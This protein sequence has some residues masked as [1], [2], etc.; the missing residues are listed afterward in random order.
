MTTGEKIAAL[1]KEKG[2]TQEQMA[3]MLNV[4]RQSVSRWE[5]DAAF[6]ETEKLVRLGKILGCSIDF[7]LNNALA[8][9]TER[10]HPSVLECFRFIRECGYFF[11]ATSVNHRPRLRPMGLI[12]AND[13]SLFIATDRRKSVYDDLMQNPRAA[14]ASYNLNRRRGIR[15]SGQAEVENDP[16]IQAEMMALY[17]MIRQEFIQK[18]EIFLVIFKITIDHLKID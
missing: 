18:D 13:H 17:P 12:Y 15:V 8:E 2:I 11:L 4:S 9:R 6:P 5:M 1:R 7:L 16:E 14:L 3:E 10:T